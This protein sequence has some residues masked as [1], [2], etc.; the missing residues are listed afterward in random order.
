MKV[1]IIKDTIIEDK[2]PVRQ[3]E[4]HDVE[5]HTARELFAAGKAVPAG[6]QTRKKPKGK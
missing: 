1:K 2:G 6:K 5:A 4:S 3:G